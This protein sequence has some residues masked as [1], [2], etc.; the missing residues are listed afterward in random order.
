VKVEI[1]EKKYKLQNLIEEHGTN[2]FRYYSASFVV[3]IFRPALVGHQSSHH[4]V[5]HFSRVIRYENLTFHTP[6]FKMG[7]G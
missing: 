6:Y 3:Y 7:R 1:V 5:H 4:M 2:N